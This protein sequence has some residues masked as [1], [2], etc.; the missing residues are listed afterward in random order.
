[1]IHQARV[2]IIRFAKIFPFI[3]CAIVC[4]SFIEALFAIISNNFVEYQ[5]YSMM[6]KPLSWFI[7]NLYVYDWK[8]IFVCLVLSIAFQTCV[9]NR[10]SILYL[11]VNL[12]EKDF[13]ANIELYEETIIAICLINIII[14]SL[15]I[16]KGTKQLI[17][18]N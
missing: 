9:W 13:F 3:L 17:K 1:M 14:S 2:L 6:I 5:G 18:H 7:G 4:L 11:C 16:Y 8:T 12:Y 10:L 15:L